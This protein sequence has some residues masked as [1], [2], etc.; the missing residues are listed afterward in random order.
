LQWVDRAFWG[1]IA[2]AVG[3]LLGAFVLFWFHY[4]LEFCISF[5]GREYPWVARILSIGILATFI[6]I[7]FVLLIQAIFIFVPKRQRQRRR[8]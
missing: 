7:T 1:K 2:R 6:V 3:R 4:P 5:I 8:R